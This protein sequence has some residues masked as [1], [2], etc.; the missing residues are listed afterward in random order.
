MN[1]PI[2]LA[3]TYTTLRPIYCGVTG[4]EDMFSGRICPLCKQDVMDIDSDAFYD[5]IVKG[6]A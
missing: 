2:K 5:H 1:E 4:F 3:K 6:Q